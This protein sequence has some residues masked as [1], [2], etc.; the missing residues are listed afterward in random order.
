MKL[1]TLLIAVSA[2]VVAGAVAGC[3]D[4]TH[5]DKQTLKL[6]EPGGQGSGGAIGK[7]TDKSSPP[8]SGFAFSTPFQDASGKSVG[9][10]D[11]MCVATQ[12]STDSINGQCTGTATVPGGTLALNVGGKN[13]GSNITGSIVGGTGK[14]AGATGTFTSVDAGGG[15]KGDPSSTDTFEITLP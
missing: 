2:L 7:A 3:S 6:T 15:G 10:I 11:A 1:K 4:S 5:G 12:P 13:I 9:Q 14:Y 8:G